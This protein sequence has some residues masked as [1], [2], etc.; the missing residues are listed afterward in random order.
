MKC[1]TSFQDSREKL[2]NQ[3]VLASYEVPL[4]SNVYSSNPNAGGFEIS[5]AMLPHSNVEQLSVM[6]SES[7]EGCDRIGLAAGA[8]KLGPSI[9]NSNVQVSVFTRRKPETA[10][11]DVSYEIVPRIKK[12]S[13]VVSEEKK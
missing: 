4:C 5:G 10:G 13:I 8:P 11:F 7:K 1:Q 3:E 12:P 9:I 2:L 6:Y